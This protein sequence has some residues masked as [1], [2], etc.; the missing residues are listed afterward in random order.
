[1][2]LVHM[3]RLDLNLFV[4]LEA[5]YSE[6]SITRA[7][8]RLNLTQPAISHAL[9]RLRLTF[10][11]PLFIRQ[12]NTMVPTALTQSVIAPIRQSVRTLS[13]SVQAA[14]SFDPAATQRTF[15]IGCRDV[16]EAHLLQPLMRRIASEAPGVSI[17]SV[18][19][20]RSDLETSL[21]K[22]E[23]D[24]AVEMLARVS[25]RVHRTAIIHDSL[26]VVGRKDHPVLAEEPDLS[27]Y[28]GQEHIVVSS[29]RRG[30]SLE[31][32]ELA[33]IGH[34]RRIALRCQQYFAAS[35]L[36]AETDLLL[37][38]PERYARIVNR[39]LPTR[40]VPFPVTVPPVAVYLYWHENTD[41][42]PA[43]GWLRNLISEIAAGPEAGFD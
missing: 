39:G 23:L 8:A 19:V 31:D 34:Q 3:S 25:D 27:A 42:D 14:R 38:M 20:D 11:D 18:R 29:R 17:S 35:M 43:N 22:G 33:R 4:I 6:G 40:I 13:G 5:I 28:L 9:R 41:S 10:D 7:A 24:L 12:G 21:A 36:V 15:T 2:N 37:T 16:L 1:M 26:V 32:V 30:M